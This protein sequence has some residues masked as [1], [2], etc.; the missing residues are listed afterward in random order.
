MQTVTTSYIIKLSSQ[1]SLR[2]GATID[3][4]QLQYF[5]SVAEYLNFTQAAQHHFIA[6]TAMSQQIQAI[7]KQLGVKLFI[8]NTRSVQLT[9]AGAIFLREAKLMVVIAAE[10]VKKTQQAA[11]GVVGSLKI[12]FLGPNEKRFLPELIRKFHHDYPMIDLTFTQDN[13]ETINAYLDRGLLDV[14][15]TEYYNLQKTP[16][17]QWKTICS[18]PIC[19]ILHRDHPLANDGKIDLSALT[20]EPFV[21][22]DSQ[23]YHGAYERMVEFC[24]TKGG[25]KP[26]IISQHR[27]PETIMLMIEA[28]MGITL[29]PHYF[30]S[31]YV[32]PNLRFVELAGEGEFVHSMVAW[33]QDYKNPS[34]PLFLKELGNTIKS[35]HQHEPFPQSII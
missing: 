35:N 1:C 20:H 10:A 16:N 19:A 15:F 13:T 3:I 9:P 26:K 4:R 6:Q 17:F 27:H 18:D 7:E 5:I 14:A 30:F 31:S 28:G 8:R 23:E 24:I 33:K 34:I 29:L 21:A 2:G 12:G 32:T 22:I 11:C 25:F